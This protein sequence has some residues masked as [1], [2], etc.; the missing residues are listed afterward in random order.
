VSFIL[1]SPLLDLKLAVCRWWRREDSK[2]GIERETERELLKERK[3]EERLASKPTTHLFHQLALSFLLPFFST[4]QPSHSTPE[5]GGD[6][7]SMLL[8]QRVIFLGGEVREN[9]QEARG[10]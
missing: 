8:D 7:F 4:F 6:P 10:E 9:E 2:I 1:I 5:L 3:R